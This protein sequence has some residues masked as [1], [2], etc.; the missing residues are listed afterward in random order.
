MTVW[1]VLAYD[2]YYPSGDNIKG[3]FSGQE[4]ANSLAF[5]IE[6]RRNYDYVE[7]VQKEVE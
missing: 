1:I 6:Q 5:V 2:Q 7:V 4:D 3:V